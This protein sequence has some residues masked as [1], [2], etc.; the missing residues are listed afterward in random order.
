MPTLKMKLVFTMARQA[1]ALNLQ[2][3]AYHGYGDMWT[4]GHVDMWTCAHVDM[5]KC[6]HGDMSKKWSWPPCICY[7]LCTKMKIHLVTFIQ[8]NLVSQ[9]FIYLFSV[10]IQLHLPIRLLRPFG[11]RNSNEVELFDLV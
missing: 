9:S 4:W 8:H 11:S 7:V 2:I 6:G 1:E 3:V 5:G 10:S